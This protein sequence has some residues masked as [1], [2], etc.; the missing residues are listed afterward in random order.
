M[1]D[2]INDWQQLI[3]ASAEQNRAIR[4]VI[5]N[6]ARAHYAEHLEELLKELVLERD[7]GYVDTDYGYDQC[8]YCGHYN[9]LLPEKDRY[10]HDPDCIIAR[11]RQALGL[12][13]E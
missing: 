11:A 13:A 4:K 6:P 10:L 1:A 9:Y 8:R 5:E 3:N 12:E 7:A 2:E